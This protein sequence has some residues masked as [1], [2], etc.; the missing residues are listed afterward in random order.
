MYSKSIKSYERAKNFHQNDEELRKYYPSQ[1]DEKRNRSFTS[2][3]SH[4]FKKMID[5]GSK[6]SKDAAPFEETKTGASMSTDERKYDKYEKKPVNKKPMAVEKIAE[7]DSASPKKP[8]AKARRTVTRIPVSS[9]F[10]NDGNLATNDDAA[11]GSYIAELESEIKTL[12]LKNTRMLAERNVAFDKT[13]DLDKDLEKWKQEASFWRSEFYKER[14]NV[15]AGKDYNTSEY[16]D[17]ISMLLSLSFTNVEIAKK[18]A[19]DHH[20]K[21][22]TE[23]I[24]ELEKIGRKS[25]PVGKN[26]RIKIEHLGKK[27]RLDIFD[28][29]L[30]EKSDERFVLDLHDE[31]E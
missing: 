13:I 16:H 4:K 21:F 8:P 2:S 22:S 15:A 25:I 17:C 1:K 5:R 26:D 24:R 3:M 29:F 7:V 27:E 18:I 9:T 19:S 28:K 10:V 31:D 14:A 11:S 6:S 12:K 30:D 20:V 23:N